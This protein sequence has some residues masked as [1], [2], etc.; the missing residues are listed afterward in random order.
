MHEIRGDQEPIDA[1]WRSF[2]LHGWIYGAAA[3]GLV[4]ID[5]LVTDDWWAFWPLLIW[6]LLLILHGLFAKGMGSDDDWAEQ[7][8]SELAEKAYDFSHIYSI[9]SRYGGA[10]PPGPSKTRPGDPEGPPTSGAPGPD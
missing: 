5:S 7:R 2:R 6:G 10:N 1:Y 3:I 4:L 9:R 8:A